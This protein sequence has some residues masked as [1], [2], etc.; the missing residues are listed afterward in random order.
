MPVLFDPIHQIKRPLH[1]FRGTAL[2]RFRW[3]ISDL[4][5]E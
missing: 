2:W 4:S 5:D 1:G 3:R